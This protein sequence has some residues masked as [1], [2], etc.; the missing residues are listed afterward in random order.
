MAPQLA[1][2][3]EDSNVDI[4]RYGGELKFN[5]WSNS[6]VTP[7]LTAGGGIMEFGYTA[8]PV[9]GTATSYKEKQIY[10]AGGVGLK[11]NMGR[12]V[13]LSLEGKDLIFNV[14]PGNRYLASAA[15]GGDSSTTG[16]VRLRLTSTSVART[17][18]LAMRSLAR[19]VICTPMASVASSSSSSP[20]SL[21]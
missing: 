18:T 10:G 21:M 11:F 2:K 7:Y 14:N 5:L 4:K 17:T 6:F 3:L 13:S 12:R 1:D 16:R 9:G 19:T 8:T 20:V 15:N